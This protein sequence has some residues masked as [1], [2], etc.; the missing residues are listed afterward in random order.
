MQ[1]HENY[2]N[3]LDAFIY[4]YS[5][6]VEP[7]RYGNSSGCNFSRIDDITLSLAVNSSVSYSNSARVRVYALSYNV[8]R[9]IN[10]VSGLA[11]DS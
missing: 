2:K 10:G 8:L 1:N 7:T 4:L 6:T 5:F 3:K 9:I 11:F